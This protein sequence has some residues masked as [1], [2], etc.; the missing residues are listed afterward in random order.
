MTF[1][2]V[3]ISMAAAYLYGSI[4]LAILLTR[5]VTGDDIRKGGTGAAGTANT[6]RILGKRWAVLVLLFDLSKS[7]IPLVLV[8]RYSDSVPIL[9]LVSMSAV[10]GHCRPLFFQFRG[11]GGVVAAMGI[12]LFFVPVEFIISAAAA[13]LMVKLALPRAQYPVGQWVPVVFLALTPV[14]TLIGGKSW[15][16]AAA[17]FG[18]SLIILALNPKVA[19]SKLHEAASAR[20]RKN[21]K[22]R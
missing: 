15:Q 11:G 14:A 4:N 8:S 21:R 13:F 3:S 2:A 19:K 12:F 9:L 17:L 5:L 1:L 22:V 6:A 10:I 16:L 20:D 7:M 18:V